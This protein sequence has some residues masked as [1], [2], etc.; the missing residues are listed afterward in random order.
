MT[1]KG[2]TSEEEPEGKLK[3]ELMVESMLTLSSHPETRDQC[4]LAEARLQ[5]PTGVN[6]SYSKVKARLATMLMGDEG[7]LATAWYEQ[8]NEK[9]RDESIKKGC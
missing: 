8:R 3:M 6:T 9:A 5:G 4:M 2:K 7:D 1:S